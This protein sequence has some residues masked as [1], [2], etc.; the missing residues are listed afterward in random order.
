MWR[1]RKPPCFCFGGGGCDGMAAPAY[2]ASC[3][4]G[5]CGSYAYGYPAYP[6]YPS[7][8]AA[9]TAA[10]AAGAVQNAA[11]TYPAGYGYGYGYGQ[12]PSYWYGR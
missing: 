11:Y 12:A 6:A 10:P 8:P 5:N 2:G 4:T 3:P 1:L 9:P 7:Y